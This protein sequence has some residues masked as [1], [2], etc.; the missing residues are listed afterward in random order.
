MYFDQIYFPHSPVSSLRISPFCISLPDAGTEEDESCLDDTR[1][2]VIR[3]DVLP[4]PSLSLPWSSSSQP[5]YELLWS[6]MF[7]PPG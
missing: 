4:Y 2:C 3:G 7:F 5:C 1:R 6:T